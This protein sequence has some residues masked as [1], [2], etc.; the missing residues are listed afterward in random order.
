MGSQ[1]SYTVR[2]NICIEWFEDWKWFSFAMGLSLTVPR[3]GTVLVFASEVRVAEWAGSY[4][5]GLWL[6]N[7]VHIMSSYS[8]IDRFL[9]L[10]GLPCWRICMA[11][12]RHCF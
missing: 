2:N 1:A 4:V 12:F 8:I 3:L 7:K 9:A 11:S 6:G 5:W 10:C